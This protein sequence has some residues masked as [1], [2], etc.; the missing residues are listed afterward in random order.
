MEFSITFGTV[1]SGWSIV[2][3]KG[4]RV[5]ISKNIAFLSLKIEFVLADSTDPDTM[6]HLDHHCLP[7]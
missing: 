6:P 5:I 4:P 1:N 2:Y 7:R 3:I